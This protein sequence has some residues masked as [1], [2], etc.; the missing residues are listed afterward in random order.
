MEREVTPV[1]LPTQFDVFFATSE[2]TEKEAQIPLKVYGNDGSSA[3]QPP[4]AA[5]PSMSAVSSPREEEPKST[6]SVSSPAGSSAASAGGDPASGSS[7]PPATSKV[8]QLAASFTMQVRHI[9]FCRWCVCNTIAYFSSVPLSLFFRRLT[10]PHHRQPLN[11]SLREK[12]PM[13]IYPLPHLWLV[14]S[15]LPPIHMRTTTAQP[16]LRTMHK[17]SCWEV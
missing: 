3:E 5:S 15:R 7:S 9:H 14:Y 2:W 13:V 1:H 11:L 16:F 4:T 12:R 6:A 10:K 8:A 17:W